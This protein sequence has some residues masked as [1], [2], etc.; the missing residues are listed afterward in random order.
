MIRY[1]YE[2]DLINHPYLSE[3]IDE[4]SA[5]VIQSFRVP[6]GVHS[7]HGMRVK[8]SKYGEPGP[9]QF[10]IGHFPGEANL[11]KGLISAG[12]VVPVFEL[13]VGE[14]FPPVEVVE[15]ETLF[16]TLQV[17]GGRKPFDAY[18][19][20]G[21]NTTDST[22]GDDN[23]RIPYWWKGSVSD[24]DE[25]D[26]PL[27]HDYDGS[28]YGDYPDGVRYLGNGARTW[29][30]SFE[31]LTDADPVHPDEEE[32]RFSFVKFLTAPPFD[33]WQLLSDSTDCIKDNEFRIDCDWGIE[34]PTGCAGLLLQA[35]VELK[36]F[37][38]RTWEITLDGAHER[39]AFTFQ[40]SEDKRIPA[41]IESFLV[42]SQPD[43]IRIIARDARG[44][45]RAVYWME[46]RLLLCQGPVMEAGIYQVSFRYSLRMVPG[47]NPAPSYSVLMDAQIWTTGYLWR[48]ARAGYNAIYLQTCLEDLVEHSAIFPEM[49]EPLAGVAIER[50]RQVVERAAS[51]GIDVYLDLKTGYS[52]RFSPCIYER[53][54]EIRS[55]ERFGNFPCSGQKIVLDF[56][57]EVVSNLFRKVEQL[58]G[59]VLIYNTEGFFSC[60]IHNQQHRCPYCKDYPLTELTTRLFKTMQEAI[61]VCREDTEL[62]LWSYFSDQPWNLEIIRA[63]PEGVS[64][65]ACVSQF[66]RL[67]RFGIR[68]RTD[69]YAICPDAPSSAFLE[70][71]TV[72]EEKGMPFLCKTEDTFGQEFVSTPYTPCLEL[73]QRRW[74]KL[75]SQ[76]ATGFLSQYVHLGFIPGICADLMRFNSYILVKDGVP[77]MLSAQDKLRL[78]AELNYGGQ[79]VNTVLEAWQAFSE[80]IH[81]YFPYTY[82]VCRY[83]GPLQSILAHPF[84]I[85]P[86]RLV[87]RLRSRGFVRDLKWTGIDRRFLVDS[88][89]VWDA[90][91]VQRCLQKFEALYSRGIECINLAIQGSQGVQRERLEELWRVSNTQRLQ[92]CSLIN[93]IDFYQLRAAYLDS[94]GKNLRQSLIELCKAESVITSEALEICRKDSRIGFSCEGAGNVRGGLFTPLA[95]RQ[96]AQSL[97]ETL[98]IL[99]RD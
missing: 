83:P 38:E 19:I 22:G 95:I 92:A 69:D 99:E 58:K 4:T 14:N 60:F 63:M 96:K 12:Q 29:S 91:L 94:G 1:D 79:A 64:L 3:V 24:V 70:M 61:H 52:R 7:L 77:Q 49:D 42:D 51:F 27:P 34:C 76:K 59:I 56:Y 43:E 90:A 37:F 40:V 75:A 41:G 35:N 48:L 6:S 53:M 44:I 16:L 23:I 82:G 87:P 17:L 55:Y 36:T 26:I 62:I 15:G 86:Q 78:V 80:A 97:Q 50:L 18:R 30:I 13:M 9:L 72:T 66:A 73:H 67:E 47:I 89:E 31:I 8:L 39:P 88:E 21:P 20:Y 33:E 74:D 28:G 57:G 46:D 25:L 85:D 45:L 2:Y 98:H 93:L 71:Q 32:Q 5:P 11:V 65:M 68:I 10:S 54:P 81:D 84:F